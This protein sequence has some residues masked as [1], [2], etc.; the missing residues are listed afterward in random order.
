MRI[1]TIYGAVDDDA[2]DLPGAQLLR[3]GWKAQESVDLSFG[4][5]LHWSDGAAGDPAYLLA[6]VDADFGGDDRQKQVLRRTQG[7]DTDA[8]APQLDHAAD[9]FIHKQLEAADVYAGQCL[10]LDAAIDPG[11]LHRGI[12]QAKIYRA[13]LD[14][15]RCVDPRRQRHIANI[16]KA[17]GAQ[18][19][20]GDI[21]G[22]NADAL[23]FRETDSRRLEGAFGGQHPRRADEAG[24]TRHRQRGQKPASGQNFC[25]FYGP[26]SFAQVF[27]SRLS[28]FRNRQSVPSAMIFCGLDLTK[29]SSCKRRL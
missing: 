17:L 25:H 24:G 27:S 6:G 1:R 4:E 12:V 13:A 14:H 20:L 7:C 2:A 5:K 10:H 11:D 22:G 29:P 9:V 19:L 23:P 16:G 21:L 15:V 26:L 8:A 28:S 18:Q 3:L